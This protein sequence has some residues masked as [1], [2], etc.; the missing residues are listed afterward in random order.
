MDKTSAIPG[1]LERITIGGVTS[2]PRIISG[3]W[4]LAGGH[5]EKVDIDAAARAMN[6]LIGFGFDCFDMADHYGDAGI[7]LVVQ[8]APTR[9]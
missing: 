9:S 4:Q 3:L 7:V 1:G 5:D 2:I 8:S 6:P